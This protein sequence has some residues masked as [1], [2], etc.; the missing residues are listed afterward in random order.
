MLNEKIKELLL[1]T[2]TLLEEKGW[3]QGNFRSDEGYC[4]MGGL[5][6]IYYQNKFNGLVY[7]GAYDVLRTKTDMRPTGWND[8]P[9][10][11]KG[12]VLTLLRDAANS[13]KEEAC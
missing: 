7:D 8:V 6:E 9:N 11:T 3:I 1:D 12:E 13:L 2:A 5:S 4:L 10:R